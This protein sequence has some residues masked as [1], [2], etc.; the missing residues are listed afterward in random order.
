MSKTQLPKKEL[1][2]MKSELRALIKE[3]DAFIE[4]LISKLDASF[5]AHDFILNASIDA[6]LQTAF[7]RR[8]ALSRANHAL[9]DAMYPDFC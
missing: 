5:A 6:E 9:F 8:A 1:R 3:Q 7:K 4:E 2:H